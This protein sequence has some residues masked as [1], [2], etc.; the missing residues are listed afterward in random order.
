MATLKQKSNVAIKHWLPNQMP[1]NISGSFPLTPLLTATGYRRKLP[2]NNKRINTM[3]NQPAAHSKRITFVIDE[4]DKQML[5]DAA[6]K[7]G[8]SMGQMLR[9][10]TI[11]VVQELES[12]GSFNMSPVS[13]S[14]KP[15]KK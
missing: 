14:K 10:A 5:I 7:Y 1:E 15:S 8:V 11:K 3:P 6:Q 13:Q 9:Q 12:K 4:S 2:I